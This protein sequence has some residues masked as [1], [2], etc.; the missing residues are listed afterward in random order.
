M[1]AIRTSWNGETLTADWSVAPPSLDTV[2]NLATSVFLSLFTDR[3]ANDDDPLPD[4][5]RD[6]RG[7]YGDANAGDD[8]MGSRLW[9]LA[10]EKRL[11]ATMQ[12]AIDYT[13][14]AL[15]WMVRD[16]VAV[17][18]E[19]TAEWRGLDGL[20]IVAAIHEA[21]GSRNSFEFEYAWRELA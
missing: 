13:N 19:V 16:G 2:S 3:R 4:D 15:A 21:D 14:E 10:R 12:K 5:S 8:A 7:W 17:R 18:V 9:L 11:P 1:Q 6:R 20:A